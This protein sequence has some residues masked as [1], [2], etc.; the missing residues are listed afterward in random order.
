MCRAHDFPKDKLARAEL[1]P[2]ALSYLHMNAGKRLRSVL[3]GGSRDLSD[4]SLFHK[5]S[6]IA[7]LAWVGLGADGLSS[8]CYGPEEIFK[9]LGSHVALAPIVALAAM[10]TIAVVCISYSQIIELFPGGGGGYLVATKLLSPTAGVISGCALLV[11]Y[12]FTIAISIA[13]GADAIFSILPPHWLVWKIPFTIACTLFLTVLN[14]RGVKESVLLWVPIFF[15][16]VE[17]PLP[18]LSTIA[19]RSAQWA[20]ARGSHSTQS[21]SLFS[22]V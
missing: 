9:T 13:S 17:R 5:V 3:I 2:R 21:Y 1:S 22:G 14:L 7:V 12:V 15:L 16:F 11:D 20:R 8:S 4:K 18:P 6:L 10:L 19:R